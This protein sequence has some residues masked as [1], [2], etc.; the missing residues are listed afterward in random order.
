[1]KVKVN[2]SKPY[3]VIIE[4]GAVSGIG[5][6]LDFIKNKGK[7]MIIT[8]VNVDKFYGN[9]LE[10]ALTEAGFTV[11]KTVLAAG[12]GSKSAQSYFYIQEKLFEKGFSRTDTVF[13]LGGGV[14]GDVAGFASATYMRGIRYV[15]IPTTLLAMTDSSV[16]GKTAINVPQGKNLVGA[17]YQPE[18]V[19]IDPQTLETL[20]E[21]EMLSGIGEGIKYAVLCGGDILSFLEEGLDK[22]NVER[23][24]A[25]CVEAKRDIVEKDEKESGL[26]KL[27]NLGHTPAHAAEKL[28]GFT[29]S[30]GHA[31][32]TGIAYIA[33]M[34]LKNGYLENSTY[35][36]I[37]NLINRYGFSLFYAFPP[38][39]LTAEMRGDKKTEG[40]TITLVAIKGVGDCFLLRMNVEELE[41]AF[42]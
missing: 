14:V 42:S 29:V 40:D 30:H 13:A 20:P 36:R 3:E 28:S 1:M 10:N 35:E 26:R 24:I 15:Q 32:A 5:K 11:F 31:V 19:I 34:S 7:A 9:K 39:S 8:D 17:F 18:A 23:Y 12:E 6:F 27:L 2:A 21:N 33:R 22:K 4:N 25:L 37:I 41:G 16:G 38:S